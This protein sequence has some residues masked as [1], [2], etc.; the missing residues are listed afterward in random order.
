[1]VSVKGMITQCSSIILEI[2]EAFF[3]CLVCGYS[4]APVPIDRGNLLD[5][6]WTLNVIVN[7]VFIVCYVCFSILF[8]INY[9]RE[10]RTLNR[11]MLMKVISEAIRF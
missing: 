6:N 9:G 10:S 8:C 3:K 1:M 2:K 5:C 7:C 11:F 4:L